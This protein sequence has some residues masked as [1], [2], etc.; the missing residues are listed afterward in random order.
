KNKKDEDETVIHNKAR[1]VAK[2][3]A[4]EVGIDFEESFAPVAHLEAVRIFITYAV[5]KS[6][7][8]YQMDVKIALLN[9]PLK[10]EAKYTLEIIHKHGMDKGQSIGTLIATK[11]KLD[12]DL[13]GNPVDQTDYRS[14]I[15]SLMYLMSSRPDIVQAVCYCAR[16]QS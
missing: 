2:G 7:P 3:C 1:L 14:K 11:P 10:E 9:G 13:S 12:A 16:Y 5:H 15:G 6:F 8:I 4:Q